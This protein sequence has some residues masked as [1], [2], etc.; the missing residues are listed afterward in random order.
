MIHIYGILSFIFL[1]CLLYV[2]YRKIKNNEN[3]DFIKFYEHYFIVLTIHMDKAFEIIYKE[4]IMVYSLEAMKINESQFKTVSKDFGYLVLKMIGP[5]L[6][7][8]FINM[9]GSEETFL[10]NVM[11]YFNTK[12]ENDEIYKTTTDELMSGDTKEDFWK[13][14]NQK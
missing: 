14:I 5:G 4:K 6:K 8:S 13:N 1:F 3:L 9:Y 12:F 10:F 11:E 7:K 2:F